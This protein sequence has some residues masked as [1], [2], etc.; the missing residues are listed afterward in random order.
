[1][2]QVLL[3]SAL[4]LGLSAPVAQAA[5]FGYDAGTL[6]NGTA[7]LLSEMRMGVMAHDVGMREKGSV[8][9][10]A[11]VLFQPLT[12]ITANGSYWQH[13]LAPRPHI[14]A[15]INA[16]GDTSYAYAGVSW[17]FPIGPV[18]IEGTFGGGIH[19]GKLNDVDRKREP[20][21]TRALFRE[22][23]SIGIDFERVR[24]MMTVEH[25]SNAGIG[26]YN[27]GLT[28]VGGKIAYKF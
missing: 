3:A 9:L 24:I 16:A 22:S 4:S 27:H 5:D 17:I 19:N 13:F 26:K 10:Q 25:L 14:G 2:K 1:M 21:G 20:L 6:D 8:N 7:H 15:S 23:A 28:H 12:Q 18:F 11:E